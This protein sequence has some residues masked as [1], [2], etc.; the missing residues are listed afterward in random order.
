MNDP[1]IRD[2]IVNLMLK[3]E[4]IMVYY[5]SYYILSKASQLKPG[6]FYKYWDDFVSLLNHKNSY[7]RDFAL[8]LL[9]NL[10]KVDKDNKFAPIFDD[11][12]IHINDA[13]FST[14][15]HC[16]QSTAKI[17]VNKEELTL[18][19]VN[20]LLDVDNRCDFPEKQKALLKS[21]IIHLFHEHYEKINNKED[22]NIFVENELD[23]ISPKTRKKAIEFIR[24]YNL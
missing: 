3:N 10:T 23:S 24:R 11:Y 17:L 6:L 16:V 13:K 5:H 20:I 1:S 2:T 15:R 8:V 22:I 18:D 4:K 9:A 14:A 19:I 21:D 7:H 12:F